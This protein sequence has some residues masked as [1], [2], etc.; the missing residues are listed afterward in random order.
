MPRMDIYEQVK[1]IQ[2]LF[3]RK[4]AEERVNTPSYDTARVQRNEILRE[5]PEVPEEDAIT[6]AEQVLEEDFY[7]TNPRLE[8]AQDGFGMAWFT[9]DEGWRRLQGE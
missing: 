3:K 1:H 7:E 6:I 8:T 2:A 5:L 9:D 4:L